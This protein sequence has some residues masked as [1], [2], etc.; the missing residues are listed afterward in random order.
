MTWQVSSGSTFKTYENW[1][2]EKYELEARSR[3][4]DID[5]S[6]VWAWETGAGEAALPA[7]NS[8]SVGGTAPEEFPWSYSCPHRLTKER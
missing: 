3:R 6:M 8:G 4:L 1:E 5:P 2:Q 7:S